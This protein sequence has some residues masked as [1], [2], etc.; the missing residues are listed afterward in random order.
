M[1]ADVNK[2]VLILVITTAN[3]THFLSNIID[4]PTVPILT[5]FLTAIFCYC[6]PKLGLYT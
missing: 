5:K 4:Y 1:A 6:A 3:N 2:I